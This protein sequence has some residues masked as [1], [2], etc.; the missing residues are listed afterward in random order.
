MPPDRQ[1]TTAEELYSWASD[2]LHLPSIR[3]KYSSAEDYDVAVDF[4]ACRFDEAEPV[5]STQRIHCFIPTGNGKAT[6]KR[7]SNSATS[8]IVNIFK[9]QRQTRQNRTGHTND[10]CD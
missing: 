8:T 1:I 2:P 7:F 4:L 6:V 9:Y 10:E 3:V 5:P